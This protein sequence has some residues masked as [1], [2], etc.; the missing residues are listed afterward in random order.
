MSQ[1]AAAQVQVEEEPKRLKVQI[2]GTVFEIEA[3][4]F[5]GYE[6][7]ANEAAAMNQLL[8][9]NIRNNVA[10]IIRTA[11]LKAAGWSDEQIKAAKAEQSGPVVEKTSLPPET[12]NELQ[13]QIDEYVAGYEFGVRSGRT[14]DPFEREVE[15]VGRAIL[16]DALKSAGRSPSK[17]FKDDRAK[18]DALLT[19]VIT[20]NR[21]E[22][23]RRA[24]AIMEQKAGI[25]LDLGDLS[26][27]PEGGEDNGE[28]EEEQTGE[29]A[30]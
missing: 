6:L 29:A 24:R 26:A 9:E 16:D 5:E 21:E 17:L 28:E 7:K 14:K 30:A 3:K 2:Q 23:E 15:N 20:E 8:A 12:H 11:K 18:Y 13:A 22:I 1:T 10:S 4:F 27:L 19:R 25:G